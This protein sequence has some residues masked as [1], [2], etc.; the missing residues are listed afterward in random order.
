LSGKDKVRQGIDCR[1]PC[2]EDRDNQVVIIGISACKIEIGESALK[3]F[4]GY[5]LD[6]DGTVYRGDI[7][8]PG[9]ASTIAALRERGGRVVFLSNKPLYTRQDYADKLSALGIP[10]E[11]KDIVNSSWV[12]SNYLAQTSPGCSVYVVGEPPLCGELRRTGINVIDEPSQVDY[13]VDYVIASFDRTFDYS[14]IN[15]ALQALRKGAKL[16][17]TNQDKTCPVESGEIPDAA[18]AIGAIYGTTGIKPELVFGK[19]SSMIVETVLKVIDLPASSCVMVGDRLE[20]DMLMGKN[21]GLAT[22][23]VLTGVTTRQ[24]LQESDIQPNY[25]LESIAG[26]I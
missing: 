21:A 6:L 22:V 13:R 26:L 9:A 23:L 8:I 4:S 14:K 20:T 12:L 2:E 3:E 5:I 16:L 11:V 25:V 24:K 15:N 17:A 19:P 7:L 18:A 1:C 10:A